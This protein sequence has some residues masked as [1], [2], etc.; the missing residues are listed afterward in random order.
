[1]TQIR[2]DGFMNVLGSLV[3]DRQS[4]TASLTGFAPAEAEHLYVADGLAAMIVDRPAEDATARGFEIEGDEDGVVLNEM[5]RLDAG[6][7]LT[8][9]LRWSGLYG[10]S[11]IMPLVEDGLDLT[12][13]LIPER[14]RLIT[15]LMVYPSV[16]IKPNPERYADPRLR[17]FNEPVTYRVLSRFGGSFDVHE[18]RLWGVPGDPLPRMLQNAYGLPWMGRSRLEACWTDLKHYRD[19]LALSRAIM[20]RKQ[21]PVYAMTGLAETLKEGKE[22]EEIVEK[23]LQIVDQVRSI[24]TTLAID[25]NDKYTIAD[26]ALGGVDHVL[27]DFKIALSAS[28]GV[29]VAVLFG[30]EIKGLGSTGHGEQSIYHGRLKQ[31][32]ERSVRPIMERL[33]A[34]IFAQS[35]VPVREPE[36]WRVV[37][38]PLWSPTEK[39]QAD[40][41]LAHANARKAEAEG[42]NAYLSMQVIA[43]EEIR[44]IIKGAHPDYEL[45]DA[46]PEFPE[47]PDDVAAVDA[48]ATAP[49][50]AFSTT[51]TTAKPGTVRGGA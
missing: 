8:D 11:A 25:G 27:R 10:A 38:L 41:A 40:A 12:D 24:L 34:L 35:S 20:E 43:P 2:N 21:T 13:P 30:E 31:L 42:L 4:R 32:Q 7:V 9:A 28:S 19:G 33:A 46:M 36:K 3:G 29:P 26:S 14:V 17:N 5:D 6:P 1:V 18:S 48:G 47:L 16:C 45:E 37:F 15:D 50:T 39:E 23:R 22:G 49:G 44:Q 51:G